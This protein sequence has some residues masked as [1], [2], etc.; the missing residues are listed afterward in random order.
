[1]SRA[2]MNGQAQAEAPE[3]IA[4]VG[5]ACRFPGARGVDAF[6]ENLRDGVESISPLSDDDLARAGVLPSEY[7]RDGYVKAA[8]LLDGLELFD[9]SFFDIPPREAA[10]MDPQHRLLLECAYETLECAGYPVA[11]SR[12]GVFAGSYLNTYAYANVFAGGG[13]GGVTPLQLVAALD[14][15][16]LATR[17]SYKLDLTGPSIGVQTA[18]STALVAVH[19]ACQSLLTY[20][21]DLALAGAVSAKVPQDRGYTFTVGGILSPDGHCRP[22]DAAAGGT[23]FG[24]GMGMV[25]LKRL[26]DALADGDTIHAVIR[27]SAVNN[28]GRTKIGYTAPSVRGQ[29]EVVAMAQACASVAPDTITYIEAHGTGTALGDPVEIA[30][31][32]EAFEAATSRR[33]FCALGSVKS[34]F[35][36]LDVAAGI[37]G[38]IK[39]ALA[40]E[41]RQIPP[42]LHF[43]RPNPQI[44]FGGSPF[45]V[46]SRISEWRS[47]GPRRAGVSSFGVGGTNAHVILEEAPARDP[48]G[49][50]RPWQLLVLSAR[51]PAALDRVA[52]DLARHLEEHPAASLADVAFTLEVGRRA[53]DHRRLLCC[54][55]TAD[56]A[57]VLRGRYP[58]RLFTAMRGR[59]DRPLAFLFPGQGTQYAG[60]GRQLYASEPVFRE[61]VDRCAQLLAPRMGLDLRAVLHPAGEDESASLRLLQTSLA[62]PALFVL[63]YAL[64]RL[65][66]SWGLEPRSLAGHSIGEYV[67]ACLA[68]TFSLP[69]ALGLV[70]VRGRLMQALP[71]GAMLSVPLAE[72]E[73]SALLDTELSLAAVNGPARCVIA[74]PEE[75]VE[76]LARELERQAVSC[77]RLRTSHA[78]HSSMMEPIVETFAGEV[79]RAGAAAP[80]T[81]FLSCV[82]GGWIEASEAAD[83]WYWARQ[84]RQPVRFAAALEELL[85]E[86]DR[87]LLEV[88]PGSTLSSLARRHSR[89]TPER[90]VLSSLPAA[91]ED[92][93]DLPVLLT[94]VGRLW[95]AGVEPDWPAFHQGESRRRIPLPTYPFERQRH[96]IEPLSAV[97]RQRRA[98]PKS[99]KE[100]WFQLPSWKLTL[101]PGPGEPEAKPAAWLLFC[102][103]M[104]L[105]TALAERLRR[106]GHRVLTVPAS[107]ARAAD[108]EG[109]PSYETL[110]AELD[111]AGGVPENIVHLLGVT[112]RAAAEEEIDPSG[113]RVFSSLVALG[114]VLGQR[115]TGGGEGPARITVVAD[116]IWRVAADD[117]P[118][119]EKALLLGPAQVLPWE[120]PGLSC[121]IL[122]VRLGPAGHLDD[123]AGQ[124]AAE[125]V[126]GRPEEQVA[127]RVDQRWARTFE[128][129]HLEAQAAP[130]RRLRAN[131][132]YLITGGLG[133]IG[134][135]LAELLAR[136][137]RARLV[138]VSR[139]VPPPKGTSRRLQALEILGSEVLVLRADVTDEGQMREVVARALERFGT[140]HGVIHGA[141]LPG[142]EPM[143][144]ATARSLRAVLAP[145]VQGTRTLAAVVADLPLDFLVLLSSTFSLAGG[146]GQAAYCAANAFLDAFAQ[147]RARE[148]PFTLSVN[149]DLWRGIGMAAHRA[150]EDGAGE[151]TGHPL[152][153]LHSQI[154][155]EESEYRTELSPERSWVLAEHTVL[156]VPVL[157]GVAYLEM[158]RAAFEHRTARQGAVLRD[159]AFHEPLA[160]PRGERREVRT[161]LCRAAD[162]FSFTVEARS[163]EGSGGGWRQH[164]SGSLGAVAT[165]PGTE[166]GA[167]PEPSAAPATGAAGAVLPTGFVEWGDHWLEIREHRLRDDLAFFERSGE[168]GP[169]AL[170]PPLLDR[171]TSLGLIAPDG[172]IF[173]P[174][175]YERLTCHGPLPSRVYVRV[176]R[177]E[178]DEA[179]A[180]LKRDLVILDE[181]GRV[182][183][184]AEGF[185]L[186]RIDAA[187]L[188][189]QAAAFAPDAGDGEEGSR[190]LL[191]SDA[192]D[193]F[194]RI[195][196][197]VTAPQ[198]AV[199]SWDLATL[200][201]RRPLGQPREQ[202]ARSAAS[203]NRGAH[204]RPQLQAAYVAPGSEAENLLIEL[205]QEVLGFARIGVHDSFFELGGDSVLA[206]QLAARLRQVGFELSPRQLFNNP[207]VARLGALLGPA[208]ADVGAEVPPLPDQ[209]AFLA[210]ELAAPHRQ[211]RSV[212]LRTREALEPAP[213]REALEEL[214]GHHEALRLRFEAKGAVLAARAGALPL[215]QVDLADVEPAGQE[216]AAEL[217][218]DRLTDRLDLAAGP[219][220]MAV[221]FNAGP[222][223][224]SRLGIAVH[225]LAADLS[226]WPVLLAD[227]LD[228]YR[229]AKAGGPMLLERRSVTLS[230]W[231]ERLAEEA[232]SPGWRQELPFWIDESRPADLSLLGVARELGDRSALSL[233]RDAVRSFDVGLDPAATELLTSEIAGSFG[234]ELEE[235][236]LAALALAL[237]AEAGSL[238]IEVADSRRREVL[239]GVDIA[240]TVGPLT[241]LHPLRIDLA[242]GEGS[243][244][245]L[246]TIK[247]VLRRIPDGGLG[248]GLL[249]HL[250]GGEAAEALGAQPEAEI[251]FSL[252]DSFD[253]AAADPLVEDARE[254]AGASVWGGHILDIRCELRGG[255]LC[256][257]WSHSTE[258]SIGSV[259]ETLAR[260]VL[261]ALRELV[262]RR[263]D[264]RERR[265][266][267]V[268]FPQADLDQEELD[269]LIA[270]LSGGT[271]S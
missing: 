211:V 191:A 42:S 30:A 107:E 263:P 15:D 101:A 81:P 58:G 159:V 3:G 180:L 185:T 153:G 100:D 94:A 181:A 179:S 258:G 205:F 178:R 117:R 247:G 64:A 88:G 249:R 16:Y 28:D 219:L 9:A 112:G 175:S 222:Q 189:R 152:L 124:L 230:R 199:S 240:R 72:S 262:E 82:T 96:W 228:L 232:R 248:Y 264:P 146:V 234:C 158:A 172:G 254:L 201:S 90:V 147:A 255:R 122:D 233:C 209:L 50:S 119:P 104:G 200:R 11:G 69:A 59:G 256:L 253:L 86:P 142:G 186:R 105:G 169:F 156:G 123:L 73:V 250:A 154:S 187:A 202:T 246:E 197:Q 241:R 245:V 78:F 237:G 171:A 87:V 62:Q 20:D 37:A 40:L 46:N 95:L 35:G 192:V 215:F 115:G 164:A 188:D 106:A 126:S 21:C 84:L 127:Y 266:V 161:V 34:N 99:E 227:L 44:D 120:A 63:E 271:E 162:G 24:N 45:F 89:C 193:A 8:A 163:A 31:L 238:R 144:F 145:K 184:E 129:V 43:E 251:L 195:L 190:G 213:L 269:G 165:A 49:S 108:A 79:A 85:R 17:I 116:G 265:Y 109:L 10:L 103:E 118:C 149:W 80:R 131:G 29:A 143:A 52:E 138:L 141:G 68:G 235:V 61:Q 66:M 130:P 38:L 204:E 110:F 98:G 244:A 111:A 1:M 224:A 6:W 198:I 182:L 33:G 207:T 196:G 217:A 268:D 176:E 114:G 225:Q 174:R 125:L 267:P 23:V 261:E 208:S 55:D 206:L 67:A 226:S 136:T 70:A 170:H 220:A 160:I 229:Q 214:A 36:H 92:G 252:P 47:E 260:R 32:K 243:Q 74:G 257:R 203:P 132:V 91:A 210:Q 140:L 76:R 7:R 218:M 26:E 259:V 56:A 5:M 177:D 173:L 166:P 236:V 194:S 54:G 57:A 239:E 183:V 150:P 102:D 128:P 48:S 97:A 93:P 75:A 4:I 2:G 168:T 25:A 135:E 212:L 137:V 139:T 242:G 155:K 13:L 51:T 18:C 121:R 27:G 71:P 148:A 221:L 65:L 19:L 151:E 60:M 83:P 113:W 231:A 270:E 53:F 41:H 77:R 223:G 133:G 12:V 14:K 216:R 157:P 39:T 167:L 134:L 22:F